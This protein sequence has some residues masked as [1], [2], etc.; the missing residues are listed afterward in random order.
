[1]EP[2]TSY[3]CA[4]GGTLTS[5]RA[6]VETSV[7]KKHPGAGGGSHERALTRFF[8]ATLVALLR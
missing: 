4:I 3:I 7:P 8:D 5:V 6:K 1:M 2:G